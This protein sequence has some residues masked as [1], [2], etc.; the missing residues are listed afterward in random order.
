[1]VASVRRTMR[2]S[3]PCSNWI[4][5][6]SLLDIQVGSPKKDYYV[7]LVCQ[8]DFVRNSPSKKEASCSI[9]SRRYQA[10]ARFE[11]PRK[12]GPKAIVHGVLEIL[13]AAEVSLGRQN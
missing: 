6:F 2:S 1:M 10:L 3:V 4:D 13:L 5:S 11:Q 7:S 9:L 12:Q 8:V